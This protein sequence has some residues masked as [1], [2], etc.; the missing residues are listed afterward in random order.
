MTLPEIILDIIRKD[1]RG[2]EGA[3]SRGDLREKLRL[4]SVVIDDRRLRDAYSKLPVCVC[5][6]GIFYPICTQEMEDFRE[7]MKRKAIPHFDRYKRVA[8]AHPHL[9]PAKGKQ[10]EL[11]GG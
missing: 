1:H 7:Y 11:F 4:W 2:R 6:E 8:L 5:E 9:L 3:I 10:M